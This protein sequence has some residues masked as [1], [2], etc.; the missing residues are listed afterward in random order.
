[1]IV[2]YA[3]RALWDTTFPA[4]GNRTPREIISENGNS[5]YVFEDYVKEDNA[6][7]LMKNMLPWL[8]FEG[9]DR[10]PDLLEYWKNYGKGLIKELHVCEEDSSKTWVSYVPA[11]AYT[12]VR[13]IEKY[14]TYFICCSRDKPLM[15]MESW[16]FVQLAAEEEL[17]V[18]AVADG[19]SEEL[20]IET[21]D[22]AIAEYPMIDTGRVYIAGYGFSAVCAGRLSIAFPERIAG[23]CIMGSQYYGADN[24]YAQ[25]ENVKKLRMPR[26]DIHEMNQSRGLLPYNLNPEIPMPPKH[27]QNVTTSEFALLSSYE[28][29]RLWRDINEC[30]FFEMKEMARIQETSD[31]IVEQKIGTKFDK[32][33]VYIIDG[34]EHYVGDVTDSHSTIMMRFI[35]VE[36]C[37][38]FTP[39]NAARLSWDFL[40]HFSRNQATRELIYQP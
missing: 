13:S 40:R 39:A 37:P 22:K 20:F 27:A 8:N 12:G 33:H 31:N 2:D 10:N 32:T 14:P 6:N 3:N 15:F 24:N 23:V 36:G 11:S 26:V 28:E 17:I 18:I 29:Q 7:S 21:L 9:D 4:V 16:G 25:K 38:H 30:N 34:I 19:N 1:M 35:G 5:K